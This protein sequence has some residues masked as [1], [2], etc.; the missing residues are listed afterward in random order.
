[1]GAMSGLDVQ[2]TGEHDFVGR[3]DRGARVRIGRVGAEGAFTPGE[4]LQIALAGCS[5]VTAEELITRRVGEDSEFTVHADAD[6]R[7]GAHEYDALRVSFDIDLSTV[8]DATRARLE[9][10]IRHALEQLCTVSRTVE[11]GTPVA[12][13]F[14]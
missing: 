7:H 10:T 5:A 3:N 4:L 12:V 6:R 9:S 13:D 11:K 8:D 2:R 1:M 14:R